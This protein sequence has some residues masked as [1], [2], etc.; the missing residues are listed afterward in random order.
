MPLSSEQATETAVTTSIGPFNDA[1]VSTKETFLL[2]VSISN[3]RIAA[4]S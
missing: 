1:E 4:H 3:A 2:D